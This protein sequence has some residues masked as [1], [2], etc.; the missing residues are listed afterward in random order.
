MKIEEFGHQR[1]FLFGMKKKWKAGKI[2]IIKI[3]RLESPGLDPSSPPKPK[4]KPLL[5]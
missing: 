2:S 3:P 5:A 1:E 4:A